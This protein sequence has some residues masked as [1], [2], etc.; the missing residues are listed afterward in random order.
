MI[1]L[2]FAQVIPTTNEPLSSLVLAGVMLA[3]YWICATIAEQVSVP[4]NAALRARLVQAH[5][6]R[7]YSA[8]SR[9]E[10]CAR[11]DASPD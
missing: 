6:D 7:R 9:H 5:P 4:I 3:G 11:V 2:L 8:E 1:F 10:D